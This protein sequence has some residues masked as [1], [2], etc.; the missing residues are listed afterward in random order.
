MSRPSQAGSAKR[1]RLVAPVLAAGVAALIAGSWAGL[2]R[3]GMSVGS[4]PAAL[5]GPLMVLGFLGTVI[6]VERAVALGRSWAWVA[7]LVSAAAV[8]MLLLGAEGAGSAT[9]TVAAVALCAAYL[10]GIRI[11]GPEPHLLVMGLGAVS[12]LVAAAGITVS[13][14]VPEVVP[15]LAG[16]LVLTIAGERLELSR[17]APPRPA[18]WLPA[19]LG[20]S[21]AMA[22]A[23]V[24]GSLAMSTAS[25][26]GGFA[27]VVLAVTLAF[28]DVARR[29][30]RRPGVTRFMA[31]ALL[32]GYAWLAL[33]GILWVGG[34]LAPGPITYDAA[35]HAVFVGFV[36]SM[37]FAH[38]PVIVP[39]VARIELPFHAVWWA[40]LVLLHASL[41]LRIGGAFGDSYFAR[42]WGGTL[43]VVALGGFLVVVAG[44]AVAAR[45]GRS[46]G[47]H[48]P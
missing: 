31:V 44:S 11:S 17:M 15:A 48:G 46:G 24:I 41:A 22:L 7:P 16:F 21:L 32:V 19:V 36:L 3:I 42:S 27:M 40:P 43:N 2:A 34:R 29:T 23:A 47:A 35:L 30:I 38:A 8:V 25:S 26:I 20:A 37:V 39:A 5:H 13:T 18:W 12:W 4:P 1:R 14:P 33:A 45:V 9:L 6:A 10:A 28:G